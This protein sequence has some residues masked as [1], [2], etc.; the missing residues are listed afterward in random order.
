[1][2]ISMIDDVHIE[3]LA[4]FDKRSRPASNAEADY[5]R[6]QISASLASDHRLYEQ[7]LRRKTCFIIATNQTDLTALPADQLLLEYKSQ[8]KVERGFRFLTKKG[9]GSSARLCVGYSNAFRIFRCSIV[10]LPG[11]QSLI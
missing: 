8:Q 6:Y 1:M 5:Y 4:K 11:Q 3:A 7:R 2:K 9:Y 10:T